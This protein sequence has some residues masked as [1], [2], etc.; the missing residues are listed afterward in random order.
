MSQLNILLYSVAGSLIVVGTVFYLR[1]QK[2]LRPL[3]DATGFTPAQVRTA[4]AALVKGALPDDPALVPLTL[5]YARNAVVN[6]A[7]AWKNYMP[8]YLAGVALIVGTLIAQLPS[9][10][11]AGIGAMALSGFSIARNVR[12]LSNARR[13]SDEHPE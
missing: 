10:G 1:V 11:A 6:T 5:G 9:A 3:V 7:I 8:L 2:Q 13:L 12:I 4:K